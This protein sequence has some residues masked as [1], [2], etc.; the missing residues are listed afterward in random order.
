ML[1]KVIAVVLV[2]VLL[3]GSLVAQAQPQPP[4][5]TVAKMQQVL[6]KAQE[7]NKAV[8][9]TLRKTIDNQKK[10]SGKVSDVSDTGFVFTDQK[11]R[12]TK[13]FAYEDVQQV[14]QKG[15]SMGAKILIVSLVVVGAAIGIGFAVACSVEGGP[16]C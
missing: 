3:H 11:T 12:T 7:K 9:V 14:K 10:F 1:Y 16:H 8:K 2:P 4:Q 13:K 15:M 6:L 5:Q